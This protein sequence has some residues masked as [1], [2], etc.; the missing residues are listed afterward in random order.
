M[1]VK[2]VGIKLKSDC[3]AFDSDKFY[4]ELER[5]SGL[6]IES[7]S[8]ERHFFFD[9]TSREG[10][11]LGL[12]VTLKDQRRLCKAK[13]QDGELI[14]KTEDLL[15]EDKLVDFNFFAIRKDTRKGI[16]QYYYSSCSPNTYGDVCKRIFYDLKKKMIHDEYVRL[17]PGEAAYENT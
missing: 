9:N 2:Y 11:L 16:Y 12:V 8:I 10:Y 14:L 1:K 17:A 15:D 5:L 4:E 7:P 3:T 13:V 6:V